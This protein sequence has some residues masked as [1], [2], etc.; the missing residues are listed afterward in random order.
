MALVKYSPLIAEARGKVGDV[1]FSRNTYGAY[2][3]DYV[4]PVQP[5]STEQVKYQDY[6]AAV[7]GGWQ[8][9]T[10]VQRS[11]WIKASID[12]SR[13]NIFGD[14]SKLSGFNLYVKLNMNRQKISLSNFSVPPLHVPPIL[15][16]PVSLSIV[17]FSSVMNL[18]V[19][20]APTS[21]NNLIIYATPPLSPGINFVETEYRLFSIKKTGTSFTL[22]ASYSSFFGTFPAVGEKVFLRLATVATASGIQSPAKSIS[23]I[24]S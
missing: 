9:L 14:G 21:T 7:I 2:V 13:K 18:S 3:R 12:W 5:G 23:K 22:G 4:I 20:V 24:A 19:D 15:V 17:N 6:Y 10:D 8:G 16:R 1:I 11:M